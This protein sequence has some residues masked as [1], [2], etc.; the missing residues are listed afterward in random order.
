MCENINS[1]LWEEGDTALCIEDQIDSPPL[2]ASAL[3]TLNLG[4]QG[5]RK[6]GF[7]IDGKGNTFI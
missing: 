5:Q 3:L 7:G 1:A 4:H 2:A 6:R